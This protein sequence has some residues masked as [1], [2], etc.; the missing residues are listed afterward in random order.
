MRKK[1][2]D[3]Q[4]IKNKILSLV[5]MELKV[6]YNKG[7]NRIVQY[8]GVITEVYPCVFVVK[9]RDEVFETLTC[10][11]QEVLCG[12]VRFCLPKLV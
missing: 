2:M 10:S 1:T 9:V 7:R 8:R 5:G 11:Y 12:E 3:V 6:R 4:E